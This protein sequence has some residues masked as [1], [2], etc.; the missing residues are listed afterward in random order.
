MALASPLYYVGLISQSYASCVTHIWLLALLQ[1]A[2]DGYVSDV[3]ICVAQAFAAIIVA[4]SHRTARRTGSVACQIFWYT[5]R[6][7]GGRRRPGVHRAKRTRHTDTAGGARR[8]GHR[9]LVA[10]EPVHPQAW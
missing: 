4:T 1:T 8:P 2:S 9:V 5:A 6:R 3:L 7:S 10:Y